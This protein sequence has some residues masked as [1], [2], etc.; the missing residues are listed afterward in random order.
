MLSAEQQNIIENSI[1]VVNTALKRQ[2]LT[3]NEDLRQSAIVYMCKCLLRYNP[4][5][6]VKWTTFAYKNV[7]LY[8]KRVNRKENIRQK[9]EIA[10][11]FVCEKNIDIVEYNDSNLVLRDIYNLCTPREQQLL[12]LKLQGYKNYEIGV[13]MKCSVSNVNN[14]MR[15]IQSKAMRQKLNN[16]KNC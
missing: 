4:N 11:E 7:Y 13:I 5:S 12:E 6:N 10:D 15:K 2:N 1:W 8:I 16:E 9:I 14:Y 3:Y